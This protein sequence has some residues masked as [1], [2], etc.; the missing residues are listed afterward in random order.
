MLSNLSI[1]SILLW[2]RLL[3]YSLY[4]TLNILA[5]LFD[6][7]INLHFNNG[8]TGIQTAN[9]LKT[10]HYVRNRPATEPVMLKVCNVKLSFDIWLILYIL[11]TVLLILRVT[12]LLLSKAK[13]VDLFFLYSSFSYQV[14]LFFTW[15]FSSLCLFFLF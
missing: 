9:Y 8:F 15:T 10:W 4:S 6:N 11:H 3:Y 12:C 5:K 7:S 13:I 14:F 2:Y 1:S